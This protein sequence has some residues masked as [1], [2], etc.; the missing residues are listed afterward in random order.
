VG[1]DVHRR[2]PAVG[3]LKEKHMI[4]K[5]ILLAV[6]LA[7]VASPVMAQQKPSRPEPSPGSAMQ[8]QQQQINRQAQHNA[9]AMDLGVRQAWLHSLDNQ[10]KLHDKLAEAWRQM[11]LP[12]PQARKVAAAYNPDMA[13]QMHHTP[14]RG[15]SDQE[16]ASLLQSA[17]ASGRYQIANQLLIDYQRTKL[18]L[19]E[20]AAMDSHQA[21]SGS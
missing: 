14:M 3:S 4:G 6:A 17:L 8:R 15:K 9:R 16:V 2:S 11:G 1:L 18:S 21:L 12:A 7:L 5:P 13:L 19:S 10:T 20:L